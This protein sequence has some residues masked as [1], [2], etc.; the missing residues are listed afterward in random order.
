MKI[1][2]LKLNGLCQRGIDLTLVLWK[3][4]FCIVELNYSER[5]F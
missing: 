1:P 5:G 4:C 2:I 3:L